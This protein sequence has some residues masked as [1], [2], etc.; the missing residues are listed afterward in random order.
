M[1]YLLAVSSREPSVY[2]EPDC[3]LWVPFALLITRHNKH[4]TVNG[5]TSSD[6]DAGKRHLA[7]PAYPVLPRLT[8]LLAAASICVQATNRRQ[9]R[10][11]TKT[12]DGLN[13]PS[14]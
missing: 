3:P 14:I 8:Y 7:T 2:C 12:G 1:V 6:R 11:S 9:T 4:F 13:P 10:S 5:A